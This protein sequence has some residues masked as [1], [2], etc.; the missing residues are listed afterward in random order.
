ML[1]AMNLQGVSARDGRQI[2][3]VANGL[4]LWGGAQ[5]AVDA[6]MVSPV[7]RDGHPQ[8]GASE[9]AAGGQRGRW[10]PAA[11]GSQAEGAQIP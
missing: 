7:R 2:E 4:P 5:L 10:H 3:V 6:T 9:A 11:R 1:H 8:P